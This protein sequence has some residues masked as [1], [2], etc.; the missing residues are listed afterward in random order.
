MRLAPLVVLVDQKASSVFSF[1]ARASRMEAILLLNCS[2]CFLRNQIAECVSS[3][4]LVSLHRVRYI[5]GRHTR[6]TSLNRPNINIFISLTARRVTAN[7]CCSCRRGKVQQVDAK[8][9][10]AHVELLQ[11]D[12]D[13]TA[14]EVAEGQEVDAAGTADAPTEGRESAPAD[15]DGSRVFFLLK[16]RATACVAK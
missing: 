3:A 14:V 6:Q 13:Q 16:V 1:G 4:I 5:A 11:Q 7:C 2:S 8:A 12:Q 10:V 9:G 15:A